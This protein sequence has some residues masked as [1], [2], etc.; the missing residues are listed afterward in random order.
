MIPDVKN[1]LMFMRLF[2]DERG[3]GTL[4][5]SSWWD[6][7]MLSESDLIDSAIIGAT[8]TD[9][10]AYFELGDYPKDE[11][12]D[13]FIVRVWDGITREDIADAIRWA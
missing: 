5:T 10:R 3:N 7:C 2:R 1:E 12:R 9:L 4:F 6:W 13:W 8:R 11:F